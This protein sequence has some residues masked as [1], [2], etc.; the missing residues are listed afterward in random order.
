MHWR[1]AGAA[2]AS[3]AHGPMHTSRPRRGHRAARSGRRMRGVLGNRRS[4]AAS[5]DLPPMWPGGL[6]RRL[7]EPSRHSACRKPWAPDHPLARARRGLVL[8]LHRR[9]RAEHP[10]SPRDHAHP[11]QPASR[12]MTDSSAEPRAATGRRRVKVAGARDALRAGIH[13]RDRSRRLATGRS[14]GPNPEPASSTARCG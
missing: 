1:D 14:R 13:G 10:R 11:A 9:P 7:A 5:A 8:V 3:S 2:T 12:L 4:V 6:L